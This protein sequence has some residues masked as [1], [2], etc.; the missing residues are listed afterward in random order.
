MF[1]LPL[2][3]ENALVRSPSALLGSNRVKRRSMNPEGDY[4]HRRSAHYLA[5]GPSCHTRRV[6][7]EVKSPPIYQRYT[8]QGVSRRLGQ[9]LHVDNLP[10]TNNKSPLCST[11]P[12]SKA[13]GHSLSHPWK[14]RSFLPAT[15]PSHPPDHLPGQART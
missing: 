2:T 8:L 13:I 5:T 4:L 1:S 10:T 6:K 12:W 11:G 15:L 9:T 7:E 14:Q 3:W